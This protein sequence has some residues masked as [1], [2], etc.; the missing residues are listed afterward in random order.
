MTTLKDSNTIKK[1]LPF[2]LFFIELIIV[3]LFFAVSGG[4]IMNLFASADI[5]SRKNRA[6]EQVMLRVQSM[7]EMYAVKGDLYSAA[8]AVFGK[9]ICSECQ[10]TVDTDDSEEGNSEGK[11]IDGLSVTFDE[12]M[13][14][15][16]T[17]DGKR[18]FGVIEL[19]MFETRDETPG[20]SLRKL[21]L[22]AILLYSNQGAEILYE[23][24]STVYVPDYDA[25]VEEELTDENV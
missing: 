17:P 12:N 24:V 3:L 16:V 22:T 19:R 6:G 2:N 21:D 5:A 9:N 14:P 20:G 15:L 13:M 23:G 18:D 7:S 4:V 25:A 8:D 10:K 1:R 11:L